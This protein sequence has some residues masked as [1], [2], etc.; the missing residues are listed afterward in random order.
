MTGELFVHVLNH[1]INQTGTSKKNPTLL[2][3]DNHCSHIAP[4]VL[5]LA[6]ENG[7]VMLTLLPHCTHRL[8]P[9]GIGIF[10]PLSTYYNQ[11]ISKYHL[12]NP[13]AKIDIYNVNAQ[14]LGDAQSNAL[15]I[16][17]IQNL[18]KAV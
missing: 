6:K 3:M 5:K 17:N 9:L 7:I 2:I 16:K 4:N 1:F 8:Q 10:G 18:F 13:G 11:A 14:F 15:T 12:M